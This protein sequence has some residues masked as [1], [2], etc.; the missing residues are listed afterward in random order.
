MK[1]LLDTHTYLWFR[2][3]PK[4]LP[5]TVLELL[6][7]SSFEVL[8][9]IVTPWE[10][11]I[12]A[13]IGKLNVAGLLVDIESRES[14]AGFSFASITTAQAIRSGLLP[15][16]HRDPFDRL[17]AAQALDLRIPLVSRDRIFDAY[18][19]QRIWD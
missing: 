16:H 1:Y 14:A 7:N 17:L 3:S 10:L 2:S 12:K 8:I 19:V 4:A 11:A 5:A 9:S 18:G 6:T 15:L 13:G